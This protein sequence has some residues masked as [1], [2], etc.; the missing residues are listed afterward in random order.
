M[1]PPP[2]ELVEA[3]DVVAARVRRHGDDLAGPLAAG[4]T[5]RHRRQRSDA[6]AGVDQQVALAAAQVPE[7]GAQQLV[8]VGLGE[9]IRTPPPK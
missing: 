9:D 5:R 2:L 6:V 1:Q 8:D 7:V 3:A 4:E